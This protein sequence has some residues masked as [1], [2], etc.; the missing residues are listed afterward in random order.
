VSQAYACSGSG[1]TI[2]GSGNSGAARAFRW[3]AAGM[4]NLGVLYTGVE[5]GAKAISG[6]GLATV[7]YSDTFFGLRAAMWTPLGGVNS[8]PDLLAGY[9][10]DLTGWTLLNASG[11]STD[12]L[13]SAGTGSGPGGQ[14]GWVGHLPVLPCL[15]NC[16]GSSTPPVINAG[17]FTCFL[18][19]FIAGDSTANCDGST[20]PPILNINDLLCFLQRV[21]QGCP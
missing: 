7:G 20:A 9:G 16:D 15:A 2:V 11:V 17:D 14:L 3:S 18:N 10:I 5:S 19:K 1:Q 21:A 12:G 8:I 13:T 6:N 4:I